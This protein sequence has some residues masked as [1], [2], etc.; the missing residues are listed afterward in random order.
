MTTEKFEETF[1]KNVNDYIRAVQ[2]SSKAI[3]DAQS[4][5]FA[6]ASDIYSKM[7]NTFEQIN[8]NG[9]DNVLGTP[10]KFAETVQKNF[11][12]ISNLAK[13]TINQALEY[14]KQ[15]ASGP[16][17]KEFTNYIIENYRKQ[18]NDIAALNQHYLDS[19]PKQFNIE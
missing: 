5:Q 13:A 4:K 8:G 6:F 10:G 3:I 16:F 19:L 11:D 7:I 2:D 14:G 12:S 18:V 1:K 15:V 9:V 17:P